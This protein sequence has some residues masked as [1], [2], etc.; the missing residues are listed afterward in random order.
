MINAGLKPLFFFLQIT[1]LKNGSNQYSEKTFNHFSLQ[2]LNLQEKFHLGNHFSHLLV[3]KLKSPF[4]NFSNQYLTDHIL[5]VLSPSVEFI[6]LHLQV[7]YDP[8]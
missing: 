6:F 2:A 4:V 1:K 3:L 5:T 8:T 7:F